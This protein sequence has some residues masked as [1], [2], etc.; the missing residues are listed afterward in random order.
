MLCWY[1]RIFIYIYL[2]L[3]GIFWLFCCSNSWPNIICATSPGATCPEALFS[4]YVCLLSVSQY[5]FSKKNEMMESFIIWW[6]RTTLVVLSAKA[7]TISIYINCRHGTVLQY[8][9]LCL[10]HLWVMSCNLRQ[11]TNIFSVFS[12]NSLGL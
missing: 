11:T 12:E 4:L 3:I 5:Y 7:F 2:L 1:Y 9:T 6:R 8:D 10:G